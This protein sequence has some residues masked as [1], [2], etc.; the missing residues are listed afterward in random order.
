MKII[1]SHDVDHLYRSDHYKDLI[2]PKLWVRETLSFLKHDI[3]FSQWWRRLLGIFARERNYI[4]EL[5]KYDEGNGVPSSFYFGMDNA[6]GM[7][8][9]YTKAIPYIKKLQSHGFDT[10]I[11]G[12]SFEDEGKMRDEFE[13]FRT[14][15]GVAP[16]GIRMHY[17]RY[18]ENTFEKLNQC[19][20][21][22]DT[23]EFIK[24]EGT[25]LKAPYKIGKMWEFPLSLMDGYLPK[26]PKG[27][28]EESLRLLKDAEDKGLPYFSIL[29]HDY[30]FCNGYAYERDWYIWFIDY[31]KEQGYTFISYLDAVKELEEIN[32]NEDNEC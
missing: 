7:S 3:T 1:V 10:G 2:Y 27:K 19:G 12:V 11:H 13:R 14:A 21:V 20:Y 17:V 9:K 6:L 29:F 22:Y 23:T 24:S 28:R 15:V 30:Q 18:D 8:Y 4:E 25:C 31:L 5:M 26:R 32:S 16:R